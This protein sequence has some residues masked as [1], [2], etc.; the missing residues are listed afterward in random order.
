[1]RRKGKPKPMAYWRLVASA[2]DDP[3]ELKRWAEL[4]LSAARRAAAAKAGKAAPKKGARKKR[5]IPRD[6]MSRREAEMDAAF[7][8]C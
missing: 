4:G 5:Q 1:M 2:Y 7:A 3:E 8:T 6:E